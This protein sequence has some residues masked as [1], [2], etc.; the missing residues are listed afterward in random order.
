METWKIEY[1]SI[2]SSRN[3]MSIYGIDQ[4]SHTPHHQ[5]HYKSRGIYVQFVGMKLKVS[6]FK[7][8]IMQVLDMNKQI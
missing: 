1:V 7:V 3:E 6:L 4:E 5:K 2:H 8:I